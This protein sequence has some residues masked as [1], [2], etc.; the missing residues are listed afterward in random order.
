MSRMAEALGWPRWKHLAIRLG[1]EAVYLFER[2][3]GWR[4][5]T[6]LRPPERVNALGGPEP[7]GQAG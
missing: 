2:T 7:A 3:I 6:R 4:R 1:I 5:A